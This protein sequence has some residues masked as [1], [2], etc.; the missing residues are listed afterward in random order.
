MAWNLADDSIRQ[1]VHD[2][3]LTA[4]NTALTAGHRDR[5]GDPAFGAVSA[6]G[7]FFGGTPDE[8]TGIDTCCRARIIGGRLRDDL[9]HHLQRR[10]D[11]AHR[12]FVAPSAEQ[13]NA[14]VKDLID[15]ITAPPFV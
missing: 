4:F 11:Y 13:T 3:H 6:Y 2:H 12:S 1:W 15:I 8:W 5:R 7:D 10:N 9:H 14:Y